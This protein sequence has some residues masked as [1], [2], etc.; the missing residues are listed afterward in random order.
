MKSRPGPPTRLQVYRTD[1]VESG[2][3]CREGTGRRKAYRYWL[4]GREEV[5]AKDPLYQLNESMREARRHLRDMLP[6][7]VG[8]DESD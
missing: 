1:A 4:P 8:P 6:P 3:V 2:Q 7:G 5:F